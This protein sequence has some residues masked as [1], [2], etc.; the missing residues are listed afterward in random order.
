MKPPRYDEPL[1]LWIVRSEKG[2]KGYPSLK[3]AA[4]AA[5]EDDQVYRGPRTL[6]ALIEAGRLEEVSR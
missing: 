2:A 6:G 4:A 1:A 3:Q 5:K